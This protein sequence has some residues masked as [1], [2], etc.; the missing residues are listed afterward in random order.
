MSTNR[1]PTLP[2]P[3]LAT[4]DF[5]GDLASLKE[6]YFKKTGYYPTV[7][8]PETVHLE[9]IAY[10]KNE[11]V[12]EINYEAKQ[13][14]LAFAKGDRLEH[15]A[16]LVGAG[17]RLG[18]SAASTVIELTFTAGHAGL[19]IPMGYQVKAVDDETIFECMTDYIVDAGDANLLANFE[20]QTPGESGNGF[21]AG[22]ISTI[23]DTSIVEVESATNVTTS[24]GGAPEEDDDRYAYRIW[25]A[26]SGW[27]SCGPY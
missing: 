15:L 4:P 18:E 21:I 9:A 7:N 27:S 17:E 24:Q 14:L 25:L 23:V 19:V 8:D 5:E 2:E 11:V 20:C 6:R 26:P 10:S 12:D 22:Q 13:N 16:A 3:S 1:F